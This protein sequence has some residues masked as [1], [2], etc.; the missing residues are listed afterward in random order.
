MS[1]VDKT[2]HK[3]SQLF[4]PHRY[5]EPFNKGQLYSTAQSQTINSKTKNPNLTKSCEAKFLLDKE[6]ATEG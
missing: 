6:V 2:K 3:S 1:W 5:A 4:K